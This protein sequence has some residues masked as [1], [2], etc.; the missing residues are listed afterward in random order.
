MSGGSSGREYAAAKGAI[1]IVGDPDVLRAALVGYGLQ[2]ESVAAK[3][4]ELRRRLQIRKSASL[5]PPSPIRRGRWP[6]GARRW[7]A[8]EVERLMAVYPRRSVTEVARILG[9][10]R[11][12]VG[13]KAKALGLG[14]RKYWSP[15]ELAR[16]RELYPEHPTEQIATEL[17]RTALSV[18][19]AANKMGL[20]KTEAFRATY[21]FQKGQQYGVEFQFKKGQAPPNKGVRR[22]GWSPGRMGETQFKK[23]QL[24]GEA[25]RKWKPIG[26][27][28]AD[29]EGFL[30]IKVRERD[31]EKHHNGWHPDVWPLLHWLVWQEHNGP[32]PEGH[33]VVFKDRNRENCAIENLECIHRRELARRNSMWANYPRELIEVIQLNAS[34]KRKLRRMNDGK[35]PHVGS[36][37]SP[38]RNA[39]A[40]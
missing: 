16:V 9:R 34:I 38:V 36:T 14:N 18:Y 20:R 33:V 24:N 32:I 23:G 1:T 28:H 5:Q 15:E 10:S 35:E 3:I 27:I 37:G 29:S 13:A 8:T 25:A 6:G 17:G 4:A 11:P 7:T 21:G 19:Q 31:P 2:L 40:A 39:G 26:T 12:S 30:R 22:P